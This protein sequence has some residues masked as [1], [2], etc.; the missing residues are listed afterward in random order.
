MKIGIVV[1][2]WNHEI[3][4]SLLDGAISTLLR[5]GVSEDTIWIERVPGSFELPL[6]AQLLAESRGPDAVI[7]LGCVIQGETRHFDYICQG[8]TNG[9]AGLNL[10]YGLP[11]IF[12][13]LT[14]DTLQQARDRSGGKHGNKGDEAAITALKMV[15]LKKNS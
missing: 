4:N 15:Y 11:F 7:C 13:V 1:S 6:G 12:G 9:I 2:E 3:T 5:H 14:T 10:K 8:V